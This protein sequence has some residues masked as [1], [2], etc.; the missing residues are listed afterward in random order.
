VLLA[1]KSITAT[2]WPCALVGHLVAQQLAGVL[3]R[4][5]LD[6]DDARLQAAGL[7]RRLALLDI[8]GARRD[9]QHVDHVRVFFGRTDH[10]EVVAHFL[11]RE[12]DVLV[13]LQLDL[14]LQ[15]GPGEGRRHLDGL[16]DRGVAADRH[17]RLARLRAGALYRP[18]HRF[19]DRLRI[20]DRL[21]VD[22]LSGVASA[23]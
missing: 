21:L 15:L 6:V 16:G 3:H 22:A 5:G 19:A 18:P 10:L 13:G 9:Q 2:L 20:H 8:L 4:E 23:A 11:H 14:A 7:D 1:P 12:G 17:R